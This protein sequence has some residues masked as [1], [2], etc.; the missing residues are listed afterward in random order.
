MTKENSN[1][2]SLEAI[3]N[4]DQLHSLMK[5][6]HAPISGWPQVILM[7]AGVYNIVFGLWAIFFPSHYFTLNGLPLENLNLW[8]CIG[9]IVGVYGVAYLIA[10][11]DISRYWPIIFVGLLGKIFGPIGFLFGLFTG[12][13]ALSGLSI[14]FFND[15]IWLIPFTVILAKVINRSWRVKQGIQQASPNL[16]RDYQ[17][18]LDT[19]R[20]GKVLLVFLR[21]F[22]C[23]FCQEALARLCTEYD[24]L[25]QANIA[26]I[27]VCMSKKSQIEDLL[28]QSSISKVF[29]I[30]DKLQVLYSLFKVERAGLS[31]TFS[32]SMIFEARKVMTQF[33]IG[34]AGLAGDGFQ[35]SACFLIENANISKEYRNHDASHRY[36]F[37]DFATQSKPEPEKPLVT[38]YFDGD[39][40]LCIKEI[41]FLK[42]LTP[43]KTVEYIDIADKS[44]SFSAHGKDCS[45]L[46]AE[47]HAKD[48]QG[49]WLIGMEAF[50]AVYEHTPYHRLFSMTKLPILKQIFDAAYLLFA[51]NR[52]R[53][54]GKTANC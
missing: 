48:S 26:P 17:R 28:E 41:T 34:V 44:I 30:E 3:P 24:Q 47:I 22:G 51:R 7:L 45:T 43:P 36:S 31:Q 14:I 38:L 12:E 54:T 13:V 10:A 5:H 1:R 2:D 53:L 20:D 39:C 35:L 27:V 33:G 40:P 25:R 11:T 4:I 52:L 8:Q 46:M 16:V 15:L 9:M 18:V 42:S 21:H 23:V 32:P 6:H 49:N 29:V 37:L 19:S 50:R